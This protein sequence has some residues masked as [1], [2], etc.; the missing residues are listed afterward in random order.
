[1]TREVEGTNN[2]NEYRA[3]LFAIT[4]LAFEEISLRHVGEEHVIYSDSQLVVNQL[5]HEYNIN[6]DR[7]RNLAQEIWHLIQ[8]FNM[9]V[10]FEWIPRE[11]N[12]AGKVLGDKLL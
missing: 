6:E 5:N 1:M 4:Y 2:E 3:V 12:K 11:E 9:K 7:L 8:Y 10:R